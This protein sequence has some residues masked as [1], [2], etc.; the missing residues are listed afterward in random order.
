VQ[1]RA[2]RVQIT[3]QQWQP[4]VEYSKNEKA[5]EHFYSEA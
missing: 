2:V 4:V 3:I 5:S 1:A